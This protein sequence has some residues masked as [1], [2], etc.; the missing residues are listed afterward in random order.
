[1]TEQS[2]YCSFS[3]S[4]WDD[5][6]K[7]MCCFA[8]LPKFKDHKQMH[9][10]NKV[11]TLVSDLTT[12]VRNPICGACWKA[13]DSGSFSMRQQ[14]LTNE[15]SPK[16]QTYIDHEASEKKLKYLTVDTGTQCNFACRTCGPWSSTGHVKEWTEKYGEEWTEKYGEEWNNIAVDYNKLLEQDLSNVKNVELLGGEPFVNLG[17]L[18]IVDL[19]RQN[20]PYWLTYTTNGSVKLRKEILDRFNGFYAVNICLS[21]DAIGKPFEYIRTLGKWDK[22]NSNIDHL[23]A[24]KQNYSRLSVNCHVTLSALNVLYLKELVDWCE[25]KRIPYDF[26]YCSYPG[27]YSFDI[28]TD[29]QKQN[30][31]ESLNKD[32]RL[33]VAVK[34]LEEST[35]KKDLRDKFDKS[36]AFTKK[37]RNLDAKEYIPKLFDIIV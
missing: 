15:G 7:K 8:Q 21:I 25:S 28:F 5:R 4:G 11:K 30:I 3:T 18:Q 1:M 26:T 14:S 16:S 31:Q 6:N 24:Q 27:E 9:Q 37:F 22:V 17:H 12:G 29:A 35:Y 33:S 32:T 13:E 10:D 23:V 19:I 36:V 2:T 20:N 34:Y